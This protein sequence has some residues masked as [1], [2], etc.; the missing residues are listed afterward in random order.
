MAYK[1]IEFIKQE[2]YYV[3]GK[4]YT[5]IKNVGVFRN[6]EIGEGAKEVAYNKWVVGK[7]A[8]RRLLREHINKQKELVK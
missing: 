4:V 8:I 2:Y 1:T 3:V 6:D 5:K 7:F